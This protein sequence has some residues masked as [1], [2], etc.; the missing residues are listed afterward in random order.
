MRRMPDIAFFLDETVDEMYRVESL[1]NRIND[2]DTL[3]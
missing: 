2:E 1:L 3:K